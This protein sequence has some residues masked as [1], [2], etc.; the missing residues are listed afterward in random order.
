[1]SPLCNK[2]Q[3]EN[4]V[5][6]YISDDI[7][8]NNNEKK[9]SVSF[10]TEAAVHVGAVINLDD[11][12]NEEKYNAYYCLDEMRTIRQEIKDTVA[13]LNRMIPRD[14]IE[15]TATDSSFCYHEHTETQ[16]QRSL[17]C[18]RGLEGKTRTGKRQRRATRMKSISAVFDEQSM[19]VMDGI[20]DPIMIAMSYNEYSYPMQV[21]AFQR[22]AHYQK[23]EKEANEE[24]EEQ[25]ANANNNNNEDQSSVSSFS[26]VSLSSISSAS[27]SSSTYNN[28]VSIGPSKYDFHKCRSMQL[29]QLPSTT[30]TKTTTTNNLDLLELE[31]QEDD[32][33]ESS[34]SFITTHNNNNNNTVHTNATN[35]EEQQHQHVV[36]LDGIIIIQDFQQRNNND[37]QYNN[38]NNGIGIGIGHMRFRDRLACLLPTSSTSSSSSSP[39]RSTT[40]TSTTTTRN[41]R[42][43]LGALRVV[44]I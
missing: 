32:D 35:T 11:Y 9:R 6:F 39:N 14:E 37:R 2:N 33:Y 40:T 44:H 41:R 28:A 24:E 15:L 29:M 38:N 7:I 20:H 21:A 3:I 4:G 5:V 30:T 23:E 8:K 36:S 19:Q 26:S 25:A 12:T 17:L 31:H 18:I 10:S 42:N 1:M 13:L 43:G 27:A 16:S 34:S 22:A